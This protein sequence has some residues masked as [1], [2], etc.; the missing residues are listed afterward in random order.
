[1]ATIRFRVLPDGPLLPPGT[2]GQPDQPLA[3][4]AGIRTAPRHRRRHQG[5]V[6]VP[7]GTLVARQGHQD[8]L[9]AGGPLSHR[10]DGQ[11]G[12]RTPSA[13]GWQ[14]SNTTRCRIWERT[15]DML[16]CI[17]LAVVAAVLAV[18][19]AWIARA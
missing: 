3:Q 16:P 12:T 10:P 2:R 11:D 17:T 6:P 15:I 4:A 19:L 14:A 13:E 5:G 7:A 1:V 9:D 18:E 8:A